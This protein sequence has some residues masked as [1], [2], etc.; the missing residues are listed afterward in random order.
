[1]AVFR[2]LRQL[3]P[4]PFLVAAIVEAL[5]N[6][7]YSQKTAVVAGEADSYCAAAAS[8][9]SK[10]F[11]QSNI[12]HDI[13]IFTNDSDLII[14]GMGPNVT[15]GMIR[16]MKLRQL[17]AVME[18]LCFSPRLLA[19]LG[20]HQLGDL[21]KPA[22][23]MQDPGVTF[24]QAIKDTGVD[25]NSD[26]FIRF[27][28]QYDIAYAIEKL[29][30]QEEMKNSACISLPPDPRIA[31]LVNHYLW[32]LIQLV[33]NKQQEAEVKPSRKRKK[34]KTHEASGVDEE[35]QRKHTMSHQALA[36]QTA[37]AFKVLFAKLAVNRNRSVHWIL[38]RANSK[39]ESTR[40]SSG[41]HR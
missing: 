18:I 38:V 39:R 22:Y 17:P 8:E 41:S 13:I 40:H 19:R 20:D 33:E 21:I 6:S 23:R 16:D 26:E 30:F 1:M 27:A 3:P 24:T 7:A 12:P 31:E 14:W 32:A 5:L 4:P 37:N 28:A 36:E 10:R 35:A 9:I 25:E 2:A 15:I 34:A 29:K 11:C